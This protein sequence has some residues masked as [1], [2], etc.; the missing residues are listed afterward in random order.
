MFALRFPQQR[1]KIELSSRGRSTIRYKF[2]DV[3]E[4]GTA[5]TLLLAWLTIQPQNGGRT[6]L[7]NCQ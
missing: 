6:F 1:V 5:S 3:S 4:E 2:V 7:Q